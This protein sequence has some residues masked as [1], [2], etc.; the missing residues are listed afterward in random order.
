M[1]LIQVSIYWVPFGE[2]A[3]G[4]WQW[5][6]IKYSY[7]TLK[8]RPLLKVMKSAEIERNEDFLR[9]EVGINV[10]RIWNF[11]VEM[12]NFAFGN[13][14]NFQIENERF[15]LYIFLKYWQCVF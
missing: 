13:E 6:K 2:G 9:S 15:L 11:N 1:P 8:S 5:G 4:V 3:T 12:W 7:H 14:L 10:H